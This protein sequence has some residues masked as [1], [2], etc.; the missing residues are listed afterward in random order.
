MRSG[1]RG[2]D[3]R[4]Q[5]ALTYVFVFHTPRD[6]QTTGVRKHTCFKCLLRSICSRGWLVCSLSGQRSTSSEVD[7]EGDKETTQQNGDGDYM[8]GA[9]NREAMVNV[10][11]FSMYEKY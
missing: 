7:D 3:F 9:S 8:A 5:P 4:N 6:N 2:S 11:L 10:V 1:S